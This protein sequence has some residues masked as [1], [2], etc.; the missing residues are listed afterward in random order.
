MIRFTVPALPLRQMKGVGK[1]SQKPY[2][3]H[4]QTV[5]V[6][7]VDTNGTP[8]PFPEKTEISHDAPADAYAPGDYALSPASLYIDRQGR[9]AVAPKL[10]P[11]K[12]PA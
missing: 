6:H 11:I 9:L 3:F 2:D 10:I 1:V 8:L 7:T 12:K 5:Y 4:I